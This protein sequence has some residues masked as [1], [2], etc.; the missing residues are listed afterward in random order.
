MPTLSPSSVPQANSEGACFE[1]ASPR[2][3]PLLGFVRAEHP[4]TTVSFFAVGVLRAMVGPWSE[5]RERDRFA[6]SRSKGRTE[7]RNTKAKPCIN[8]STV[9]PHEE[10]VRSGGVVRCQPCT[11]AKALKN[12]QDTD[13]CSRCGDSI[14]AHRETTEYGAKLCAECGTGAAAAPHRASLQQPAAHHHVGSGGAAEE[15]FAAELEKLMGPAPRRDARDSSGLAASPRAA[16]APAAQVT[17]AELI[18]A[19]DE[20][21]RQRGAS[22]GR[23]P[24][25]APAK[26]VQAARLTEEDVAAE[27]EKLMGSPAA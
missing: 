20:R 2:L 11:N 4:D 12:A 1:G 23:V 19:M 6:T 18:V 3:T 26:P 10:Q 16:G 21:D 25:A 5:S 27:L 8:C 24:V 17:E 22:S 7:V 9:L 14:G 13:Q 15:E